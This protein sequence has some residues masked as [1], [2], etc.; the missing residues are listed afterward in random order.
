MFMNHEVWY[1]VPYPKKV[2]GLPAVLVPSLSDLIWSTYQHQ[3]SSR[4]KMETLE[5]EVFKER[6]TRVQE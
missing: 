2:A 3:W 4:M 6:G 1:S 5:T